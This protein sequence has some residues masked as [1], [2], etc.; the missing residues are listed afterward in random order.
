[1][2]ILTNPSFRQI[3]NGVLLGKQ[4]HEESV[5][6]V[7]QYDSEKVMTL[8]VRALDATDEGLLVIAVSDDDENDV[9]GFMFGSVSEAYF[10]HDRIARDYAMFVK[11]DKRG[12]IA[13]V[14]MLKAYESLAAKK[15]AVLSFLGTTTGVDAQRTLDLYNRLGYQQIGGVSIKQLRT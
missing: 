3:A 7:M 2:K 4:M 12:G 9:I 5:Y 11:N 1:M 15:G 14:R 8:A 6:R 13:A 10:S